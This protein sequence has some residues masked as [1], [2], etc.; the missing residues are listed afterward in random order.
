MIVEALHYGADV[1]HSF[2]LGAWV[3]MPNHVHIVIQ[4][5]ESLPEMIRWLKTATA[6]R[7]K[8]ILMLR[9]GRFWQREYYDHW[10]RSRE[11]LARISAYIERNPVAAGLISTPTNWPWSSTN[12]TGGKTAGATLTS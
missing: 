1:R 4:P 2:N 10:I 6:T 8:K 11:E 5:H 7:A 9:P 12:P 3:V